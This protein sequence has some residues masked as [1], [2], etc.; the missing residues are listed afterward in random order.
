MS[1]E[2]LGVLGALPK[3]TQRKAPPV[4]AEMAEALK[5]CLAAAVTMGQKSNCSRMAKG[6]PELTEAQMRDVDLTARATSTCFRRYKAGVGSGI[7][8]TPGW[9][10]CMAQER[11]NP[12]AAEAAAGKGGMSTNTMLLIG[13]GVVVA[14]GLAWLLLKK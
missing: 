13:G 7:L 12:G 6:L 10:E 5:A 2:G 8:G 3:F 4:P 11:L 9:N 1:Y 14:A